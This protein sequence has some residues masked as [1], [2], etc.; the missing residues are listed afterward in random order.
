MRRSCRQVADSSS[1]RANTVPPTPVP[2]RLTVPRSGRAMMMPAAVAPLG[3]VIRAGEW[4]FGTPIHYPDRRE[5]H[6][7][8]R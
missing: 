3:L 4:D 5:H 7:A 2:P 8:I 1:E 6:P